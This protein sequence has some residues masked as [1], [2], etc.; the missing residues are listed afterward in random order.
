MY[1]WLDAFGQ[2]C[3]IN[4][5]MTDFSVIK[6]LGNTEKPK[7]YMV[8]EKFTDDIYSMKA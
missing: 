7:R 2:A 6:D 8:K 3:I 4:Y 1:H 5:F